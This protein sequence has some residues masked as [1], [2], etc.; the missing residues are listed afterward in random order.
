MVHPGTG[1]QRAGVLRTGG[2]AT[3]PAVLATALLW[4]ALP[5]LAFETFGVRWPNNEVR[6]RIHANFPDTALSGTPQEQVEILRC[7]A[8][9]WARQGAAALD[10]VYDGPTTV[11]TDNDLDDGVNTILWSE[12][13]GGQALAVT[14]IS[15]RRGVAR[16]FDMIF[17]GQSVLGENRW[18]G[19]GDSVGGTLDLAGVA[20]HEFGHA[21]GLDHSNVSGAT[22]VPS[23]AGNGLPFRTL[24]ED[25]QAGAQFLYGRDPAASTTPVIDAVQPAE[26]PGSGGNAVVLHGWNFTWTAE[27]TLRVAGQALPRSEYEVTTCGRIDV[28][29][30]PPGEAGPVTLSVENSTGATLIE[31]AYTYIDSPPQTRFVRGDLNEDGSLDL[32]DPVF[33][34]TYLFA[35][36]TEPSCQSAADVDA[37]GSVDPTDAVLLLNFLFL[38]GPAPREPFPG[39]G[40]DDADSTLSCESF[41]A[42]EAGTQG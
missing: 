34:L 33:V 21:L 25:D 11:T 32:A 17:F 38:A 30:M 42:C 10:F 39:C 23:V 36:G 8:G 4:P 3:F 27:T 6:F 37:S 29:A 31:G 40:E 24:H 41:S 20:T 13:D 12:E 16:E 14:L 7:A 28:F 18:S 1:S 26:G 35:A 15:G 19:L 2:R 22:M 5:S 9:T